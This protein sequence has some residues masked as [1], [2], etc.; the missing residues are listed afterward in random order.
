MRQ[1]KGYGIDHVIFHSEKDIDEML[2]RHA[3]E[4][5]IL[6]CRVFAGMKTMDVSKWVDEAA[7]L[8]NKKYGISWEELEEM[9]IQ[10][11]NA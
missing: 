3:I 7:E 8:L 6:R 4:D 9:E 5:Y 2:K 1:Y 10:A 11:Y